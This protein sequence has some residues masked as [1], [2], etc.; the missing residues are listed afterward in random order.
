L[1]LNLS[2]KIYLF[3]AL[4]SIMPSFEPFPLKKLAA[5]RVKK[6]KLKYGEND[7]PR[8]LAEYLRSISRE[9]VEKRKLIQQQLVLLLHAYKCQ[10]REALQH[11]RE[12]VVR[13]CWLPHC[14]TMKD[15]LNHMSVCRAGKTCP[16]PRCGSSTRIIAHWKNCSRQDC[17]VC[18]PLKA[19][20]CGYR[21][22]RGK[23]VPPDFDNF[24][25]KE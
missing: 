16:A 21:V 13:Q 8:S 25:F 3:P 1:N 10:R 11:D 24:S 15:V 6:S 19:T 2:S 17:P 4:R 7:L 12:V 18:S 5:G 14:Q 20:P 23:A 22:T 9:E